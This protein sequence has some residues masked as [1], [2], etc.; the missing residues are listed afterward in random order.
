M[1][2]DLAKDAAL[3]LVANLDIGLVVDARDLLVA[4][5]DDTNFGGGWAAGVAH[6]RRCDARFPA[7]VRECR[8]AIVHAGDGDERRL[9]AS[10]VMLCAT[11][12]APPIRNIS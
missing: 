7:G 4:V 11:L 9:A 12:A 2:L 6:K 8:G 3:D 1:R 10:A 5:G